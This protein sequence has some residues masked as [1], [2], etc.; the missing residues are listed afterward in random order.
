MVMN[1]SQME[2]GL[3]SKQNQVLQFGLKFDGTNEN[4][5]TTVN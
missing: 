5:P 1:C 2:L 4:D 3:C